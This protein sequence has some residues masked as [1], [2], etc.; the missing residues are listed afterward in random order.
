MPF[1]HAPKECHRSV[2]R[3][4]AP[5]TR[6]S[7]GCECALEV[8]WICRSN[9]RPKPRASNGRESHVRWRC[10]GFA[11]RTCRPEGEHRMGVKAVLTVGV[12]VW[13]FSATECRKRDCATLT[14]CECAKASA[15]EVVAQPCSC[16]PSCDGQPAPACVCGGGRFLRLPDPVWPVTGSGQARRRQRRHE[17]A[18][19]RDEALL[20]GQRFS[21]RQAFRVFGDVGAVCE[22]RRFVLK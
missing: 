6:A 12:V 8:S 7:H 2:V 21:Q 11:A 15:C 16:P 14:E 9:A 3:T 10:H 4:C 5:K 1:E 13:A 22:V 17:R 20:L 18:L 19:V